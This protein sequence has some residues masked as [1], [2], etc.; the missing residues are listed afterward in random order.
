MSSFPYLFIFLQKYKRIM[1]KSAVAR[2]MFLDV[3]LSD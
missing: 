1:N 3:Q 2:S